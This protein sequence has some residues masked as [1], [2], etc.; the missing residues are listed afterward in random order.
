MG[1]FNLTPSEAEIDSACLSIDHS[2]GL[3]DIELQNRMRFEA[4]EWLHAWGK[5]IQDAVPDDIEIYRAIKKSGVRKHGDIARVVA[6]IYAS[7]KVAPD[8]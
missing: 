2:F 4:R 8:A 7:S 3:M 5:E 6:E 1:R